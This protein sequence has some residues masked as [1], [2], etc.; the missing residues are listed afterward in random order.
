MP[1][2]EAIDELVKVQKDQARWQKRL[3]LA[4][5]IIVILQ[6]IS[7]VVNWHH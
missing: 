3:T 4:L 7:Y 6:V 1:M 5:I 2:R